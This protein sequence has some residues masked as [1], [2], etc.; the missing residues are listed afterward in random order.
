MNSCFYLKQ[1]KVFL[2]DQELEFFTFLFQ[3]LGLILELLEARLP[4]QLQL[5]LFPFPELW[6][7][8]VDFLCQVTRL[9]ENTTTFVCYVKH[10]GNQIG[11]RNF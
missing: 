7:P 1:L 6:L 5:A 3:I 2:D 11:K 8:L 10:K 9:E 4:R